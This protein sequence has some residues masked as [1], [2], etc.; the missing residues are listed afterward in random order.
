MNNSIKL[1]PQRTLERSRL[2]RE[3]I[4]YLETRSGSEYATI[5]KSETRNPL[6]TY[7]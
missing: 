5:K 4:K 6:T 3:T 2:R 1:T 7:A